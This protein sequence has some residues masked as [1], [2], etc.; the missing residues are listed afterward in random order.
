MIAALQI[1]QWVTECLVCIF[2]FS[3]TEF[4]KNSISCV[5]RR[6]KVKW[7]QNKKQKKSETQN[8]GTFYYYLLSCAN[9]AVK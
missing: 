9:V 5:V 8:K 2:I 1:K 7:N 3:Y 4:V 6:K